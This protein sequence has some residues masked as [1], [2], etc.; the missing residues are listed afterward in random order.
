M[1]CCPGL[2][3]LALF[4]LLAA[5]AGYVWAEPQPIPQEVCEQIGKQIV[6]MAEKDANAP[7]KVEG[8]P[9]KAT[10]LYEPGSGGLII[11]PMKGIKDGTELKGVDAATGAPTG[12]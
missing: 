7:F 1:R 9:S 11:V 3:I 4:A 12:D 2:K 5:C 10:G 8:D 6:E